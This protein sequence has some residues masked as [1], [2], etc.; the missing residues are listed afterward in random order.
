MPW[1]VARDDKATLVKVAAGVAWQR[2]SGHGSGGS[3]LSWGSA[4][5]F[6]TC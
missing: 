4:Y 1:V 5:A 6:L 2:A 3:A